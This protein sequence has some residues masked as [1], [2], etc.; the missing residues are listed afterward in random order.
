[1]PLVVVT[2]GTSRID[3]RCKINSFILEKSYRLLADDVETVYIC[4]QR[5]RGIS[6]TYMP[7]KY[8]LISYKM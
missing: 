1:M 4:E 2:I 7:K 8:F 6:I 3:L 5:K